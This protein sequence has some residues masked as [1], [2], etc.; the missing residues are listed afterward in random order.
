[1]KKRFVVVPPALA[2]YR[3]RLAVL[4]GQIAGALPLR[5]SP[6]CALTVCMRCVH[7]LRILRFLSFGFSA[8]DAVTS[9]RSG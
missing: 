9:D 4:F 5:P 8:P 2:I 7:R 3:L 1:M 6:Q